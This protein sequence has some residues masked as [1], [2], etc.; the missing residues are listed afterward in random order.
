MQSKASQIQCTYTIQ[1]VRYPNPDA[2]IQGK[3]GRAK[4]MAH[5]VTC[6]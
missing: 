2:F 5:P 6:L 4:I 3:A 1:G